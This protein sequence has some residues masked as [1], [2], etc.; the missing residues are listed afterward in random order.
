MLDLTIRN[1]PFSAESDI[2][3]RTMKTR[4]GLDRNYIC[5]I[6]YC[7]SLEEPGIPTRISN[8]QKGR[9]EIERFTLLGRNSR[10]YLALLAVWMRAHQ[11]DLDE[12]LSFDDCFIDHMNR[13]VELITSRVRSLVDIG[14]LIARPREI[15]PGR[16]GCHDDGG[17]G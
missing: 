11:H 10:V 7:L 4:L 9:R 17:V 15:A 13:G 2:R 8:V 6:G 14:S 12:K 16:K 3:L 1:V 5:R